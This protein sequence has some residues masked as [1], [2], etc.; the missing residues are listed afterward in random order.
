[1]TI[2]KCVIC[3]VHEEHQMRGDDRGAGSMGRSFRTL[4]NVSSYRAEQSRDPELTRS[5]TVVHG[6]GRAAME[7]IWEMCN[8]PLRPQNSS[9]AVSVPLL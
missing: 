4:Q 1:M 9:A 6:V 3:L 7:I 8:S 2:G 5:G